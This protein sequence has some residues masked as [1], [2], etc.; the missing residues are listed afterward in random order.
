MLTLS[1][2]QFIYLSPRPAEKGTRNQWCWRKTQRWKWTTWT[3]KSS[4]FLTINQNHKLREKLKNAGWQLSICALSDLGQQQTVT[5]TFL[6]SS[7]VKRCFIQMWTGETAMVSSQEVRCELKRPVLYETDIMTLTECGWI[8]ATRENHTDFNWHILPVGMK[9]STMHI[10]ISTGNHSE[11]IIFKCGLIISIPF[12]LDLQSSKREMD[13]MTAEFRCA[14]K[15]MERNPSAEYVSDVKLS[16]DLWRQ[17]RSGRWWKHHPH[18]RQ[19]SRI[20]RTSTK[21]SHSLC[22]LALFPWWVLMPS[23]TGNPHT[24]TCF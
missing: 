8:F 5:Q 7:P 12:L 21:T 22:W 17:Q 14:F 4:C 24:H 20:P 6:K 13:M 18:G 15:K 3:S 23:S 9:L 16:G 1:F 10:F 19:D 2:I 11:Q